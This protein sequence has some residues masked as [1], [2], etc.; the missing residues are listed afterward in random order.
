MATAP[1]LMFLDADDVLAGEFFDYIALSPL[2]KDVDFILF[3]HHLCRD[4][5]VLHS[6]DMHGVD[7]R[8][9]SNLAASGFDGRGFALANLPSA[10]RTINFPW[11]KL[12]RTEFLRGQNIRFPDL[13]IHEDIR[14]H[15]QGFLRARR[16]GVLN[17]APPLV[18]HVEEPVGNR[19]TNYVGPDR[20]VAFDTM[21]AVLDEIETHPLA[22][23]LAAE[24]AEF[25]ADLLRWM[26]ESTPE[27]TEIFT[28]AA[29]PLFARI[30]QH[31]QTG[32]TATPMGQ[33]SA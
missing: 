6:Y 19:A 24:L 2:H 28:Q 23:L 5:K 8:F 17:W 27:R 14:P 18:H 26:C 4:P 1:C 30:G 15:W 10:I 11:N 20:V 3:K 32:I 7:N 25:A 13:R 21:A 33:L 29:A 16:F 12:Y 22:G 9:F 31:P